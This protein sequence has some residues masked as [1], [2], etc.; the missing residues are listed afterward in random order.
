M[1]HSKEEGQDQQ[2]MDAEAELRG[3]VPG[4]MQGQSKMRKAEEGEWRSEPSELMEM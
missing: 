2:W 3:L 1:A 4:G